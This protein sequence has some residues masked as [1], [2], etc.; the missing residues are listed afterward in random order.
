MPGNVLHTHYDK[1]N[2]IFSNIKV[3][4]LLIANNDVSQWTIDFN[5]KFEGVDKIDLP[6]DYLYFIGQFGEGIIGDYIKIFPIMKI[7]NQTKLWRGCNQTKAEIKFFKKNRRSDCTLIG[8]LSDGDLLFYLN[9]QY[10][11]LASLYEEKIYLL[12]P[13]LNDLLAFFKNHKIYGDTDID[14]FVPFDSLI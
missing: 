10:Y 3:Q 13:S 7:V 11:F 9:G 2:N 5:M 4:P 1:A 12:G 14:K 8:E 6:N